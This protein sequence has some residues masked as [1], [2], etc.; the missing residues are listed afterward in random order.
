MNVYNKDK[1]LREHETTAV[2]GLSRTTRW[3]LEKRGHFPRKYQISAGLTAYKES[4]VMQWMETRRQ[5]VRT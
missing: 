3:R 5:E 2:S 1:F 4:E